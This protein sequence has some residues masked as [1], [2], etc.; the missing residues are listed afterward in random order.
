MYEVQVPI[1]A[2][3]TMQRNNLPIAYIAVMQISMLYF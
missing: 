1:P 3:R 2:G